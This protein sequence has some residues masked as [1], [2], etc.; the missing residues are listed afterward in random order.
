MSGNVEDDVAQMR[1]QYKRKLACE[2]DAAPSS[3]VPEPAPGDD[4]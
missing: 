3:P 2:K 1:E 4:E